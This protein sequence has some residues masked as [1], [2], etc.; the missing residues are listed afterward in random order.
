MNYF[1]I[2]IGIFFICYIMHNISK[3]ILSI[4]E[5]FFWVLACIG[6]LVLSIFPKLIDKIAIALD[7]YYPPSMLFLVCI[8]FLLYMNFRNAQIISM[9]NKKITDLAQDLAILNNKAW[10]DTN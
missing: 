7:V 2:I 4:K 5:S 6:I 3:N 1:F 9:Q 8:I 10:R